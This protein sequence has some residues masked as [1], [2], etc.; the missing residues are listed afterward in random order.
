MLKYPLGQQAIADYFYETLEYMTNG[1][2]NAR[3]QIR[4]MKSSAKT[5][6]TSA[7]QFLG[8]IEFIS[9]T[10]LVL[11]SRQLQA[12]PELFKKAEAGLKDNHELMLLSRVVRILLD[13]CLD[14]SSYSKECNQVAGMAIGAFL[15]LANNAETTRDLVLG[16]FFTNT[17]TAET[18]RIIS[19]LD[20]SDMFVRFTETQCWQG[21][22]APIIFILRG[23]SSSLRKEVILLD[24]SPDLRFIDP[25]KG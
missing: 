12:G 15:N 13:I 23:L 19:T 8:D 24:C 5:L 2:Q 4:N 11:F 3:D 1:L 22:D 25:L 16:C 20:I 21:R 7:D 6:N 9:K 18:E 10:I 14:T 17:K